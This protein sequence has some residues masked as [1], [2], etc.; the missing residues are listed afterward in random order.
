MWYISGIHALNIPCSLETSGDWHTSALKWKNIYMKNT[1]NS[2]Y[3]EWGIEG[4][5]K[6]PNNEGLY[7]VA[8]HIRALL[9][10]LEDGKYDVAQGMR[11]DYICNE[12]Y[13]KEVHDMVYKMKQ[14]EHWDTINDFMCKEYKI[15]WLRY[16]G[17]KQK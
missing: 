3:G 4:N 13:T 9:D 10:L 7:Y 12:K 8:N 16:I 1:E 5:K 2:I 11:E 14:L 15:D 6:I 17:G